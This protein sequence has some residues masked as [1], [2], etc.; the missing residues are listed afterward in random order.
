M[1]EGNSTEITVSSSDGVDVDEDLTRKQSQ[2]YIYLYIQ[3][4]LCRKETLDI[5]LKKRRLQNIDEFNVYEKYREILKAVE[6]LHS[7][8]VYSIVF[9][10]SLYSLL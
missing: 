4:E 6:Y 9:R 1:R 8:V 3:M 5:W 2:D 10:I 7:Q